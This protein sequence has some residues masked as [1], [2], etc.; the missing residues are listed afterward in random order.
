[1]MMVNNAAIN[2]W[3]HRCLKFLLPSL[4]DITQKWNCWIIHQFL[5]LYGPLIL[6]PIFSFRSSIFSGEK[7]IPLMSIRAG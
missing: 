7:S 3:L 6:F 2:T 1:L 5:S 4:W